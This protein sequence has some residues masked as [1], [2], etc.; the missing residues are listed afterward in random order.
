MAYAVLPYLGC[1]P[2]KAQLISNWALAHQSCT[3]PLLCAGRPEVGSR[4]LGAVSLQHTEPWAGSA[5]TVFGGVL[6]AAQGLWA[7]EEGQLASPCG[8]RGG[9]GDQGILEGS[10]A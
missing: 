6:G 9:I 7:P 10:F 3:G 5:D 1:A 8:G 4:I 2:F